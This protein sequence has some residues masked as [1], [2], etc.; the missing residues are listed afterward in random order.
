MK[1]IASAMLAIPLTTKIT[2]ELA[3][4]I[5]DLF[6][7]AAIQQSFQRGNELQLVEC[8]EY[9]MGKL[10]EVAAPTYVPTYQDIIRCRVK[11]TGIVEMAFMVGNFTYRIVDIGG[12]RSERRKWIHFFEDVTA[13]I[14]VV[15]L[16]EYDMNLREDE[17]VNRMKESLSLFRQICNQTLLAQK[18][19]VLF[20]NKSDLFREKLKKSDLQ[21]CFPDYTGGA[22]CE[23]GCEFIGNTFKSECD[24][25]GRSIYVHVTCATDTSDVARVFED[26]RRSVLTK[27]LKTMGF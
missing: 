13:I 26:V 3:R 16:N 24:N 2:P 15:A 9:F 14:F 17:T 5:Q 22:D 25:K 6:S 21:L 19:I 18:T 12:Q 7:D 8:V 27:T 10:Q 4:N 23:K 20:L 11:T 1:P